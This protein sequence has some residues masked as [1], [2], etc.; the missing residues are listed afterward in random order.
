MFGRNKRHDPLL[1]ENIDMFL[2][3]MLVLGVNAEEYKEQLTVVERLNKLKAGNPEKKLSHDT[4]A[5]VLG[6]VV[7]VVIIVAYEQKHVMASKAMSF[8]SRLTTRT[9]SSA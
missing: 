3:N 7:C 9:G 8:V 2:E 1:D 4:I 5:M 6:N